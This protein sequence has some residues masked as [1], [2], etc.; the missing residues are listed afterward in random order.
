MM[1]NVRWRVGLTVAVIALAIW[2]FYPPAQKINLGLDLK[3]GVHLVLK[4]QTDDAVRIETE[5]TSE[6]VRDAMTRAG[7]QFTNVAVVPPRECR[8]E[9]VQDEAAFRDA[10]VD[11]ETV[12]DRS[13]SAG[14]S[15]FRVKPN[16]ENEL[17][18]QAVDQALET[19][20][21]RVNELGVAEPIVARQGGQ[22]RILVQ[23]PG[24]DNPERAKQ[25]IRSTALLQLRLV[26]Q[27]PFP[28]R[29]AAMELAVAHGFAERSDRRLVPSQVEVAP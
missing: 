11:V 5:T 16:I 25:I 17:R 4:V 22:D 12:F 27:G 18:R 3:G 28:T 13:S 19:I 10:T 23:L 9:G 24:V 29:E 8:V 20:E 14:S 21:R 6:R 2:A 1:K 26:E 15:T 7:V